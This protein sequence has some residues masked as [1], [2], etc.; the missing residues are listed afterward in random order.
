[1]APWSQ[2]P[3]PACSEGQAH[4]AGIRF[5]GLN[6]FLLN[7]ISHQRG[8][9]FSATCSAGFVSVCGC[10]WAL[11]SLFAQMWFGRAGKFP[12]SRKNPDFF[13]LKGISLNRPTSQVPPGIFPTCGNFFKPDDPNQVARLQE[14]PT[15][16]KFPRGKIGR[17]SCG[18][19]KFPQ[20]QFPT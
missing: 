3:K 15:K 9:F 17:W 1:M 18:Y 10:R 4:P 7:K 16:T 13:L 19:K 14:I 20:N 12:T 5:L 11:P 8:D 2:A 6:Y